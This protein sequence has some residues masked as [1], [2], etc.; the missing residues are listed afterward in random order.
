MAAQGALKL[1]ERQGQ[2]LEQKMVLEIGLVGMVMVLEKKWK[3]EEQWWR[4]EQRIV[5]M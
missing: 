1:Q 5:Q 3:E 4:Q 2:G